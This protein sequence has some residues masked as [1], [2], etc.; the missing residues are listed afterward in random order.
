MHKNGCR[1]EAVR[2]LARLIADVEDSTTRRS[3]VAAEN[4]TRQNLIH[5][6]S[7]LSR[8]VKPAPKKMKRSQIAQQKR[9]RAIV[10]LKL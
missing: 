5:H 3:I 7:E 1:K 8:T 9:E 4:P 10:R 2:N 6:P